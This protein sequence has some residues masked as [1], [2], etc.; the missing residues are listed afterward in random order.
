MDMVLFLKRLR[1][2][3]AQPL[4]YYGVGEYGD[5]YGRPH[6]HLALFGFNPDDY[7]I[8]ME[9][10]GLGG[11]HVCELN[12]DTAQYITGYVTK[13]I[14]QKD[15]N[16]IGNGLHPEFA[17]MS[18]GRKPNG[19]I[20]YRALEMVAVGLMSEGG[21]ARLAELGDVPSSIKCG[22]K[23]FP[24]GRYLRSQLRTMVGWPAKAPSDSM[25]KASAE[26]LLEGPARETRRYVHEITAEFR[27]KMAKSL[28]R[29]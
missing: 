16:E 7:A 14:G 1:K 20:G 26:V 10:W 12:N 24:L 3:Y 5:L 28:R 2:R 13:K 23:T 22:G 15:W 11:V 4:R 19:G 6:F 17:R 27:E 9:A 21:S 8:L 18:R 25:L 29:L